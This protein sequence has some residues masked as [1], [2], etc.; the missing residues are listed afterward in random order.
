MSIMTRKWPCVERLM[1]SAHPKLL[2]FAMDCKIT[3]PH[4][5]YYIVLDYHIVFLL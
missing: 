3:P 1:L 4:T 2:F 5:N